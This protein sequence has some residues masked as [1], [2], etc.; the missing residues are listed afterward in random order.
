MEGYKQCHTSITIP[1]DTSIHLC[2]SPQKLSSKT[3]VLFHRLHKES[4]KKS[5][6]WINMIPSI[7]LKML[8]THVFLYWY[9]VK[10]VEIYRWH[11]FSTSMDPLHVFGAAYW[12][13]FS[14]LGCV[15]FAWTHVRM[16]NINAESV[17]QQS[18]LTSPL[19][20]ADLIEIIFAI[21]YCKDLIA[22]QYD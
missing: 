18:E 17:K 22:Q 8:N 14:V 2:M 6:S 7:T 9:I 4:M 1:N 3:I 13:L 20:V 19:F 11:K 5:L 16:S 15:V 10:I 12:F 21:N